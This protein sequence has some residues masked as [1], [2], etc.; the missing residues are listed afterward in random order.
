[1]TN[2]ELYK[3]FGL[4]TE[5]AL[6]EQLK[7]ALELRRDQ[8]QAAVLRKQAVEKISA[9][10]EMELP[11]K[12]TAMQAERDLQR[13]RTELQSS[14]KLSLD[15]V[16]AEVAK[17][18]SGSTEQSKER[19]KNFF[20][21]SKLA[22]HF[23]VTVGEHEV[24]ARIAEI[25]M[26]NGMRPEEMRSRLA[27]QGQLPQIQMVVKEDKAADQLVAAC[28]VKE[29]SLEE[30][31]A[32]QGIESAPATKKTKKKSSKKTASKKK[33]KKKTTKKTKKSSEKS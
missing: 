31:Q 4:E 32:S 13:M 9:L 29:I 23:H 6:K 5:D 27:E 11:E 18:R 1:M 8:D 30:W 33:T 21:L 16:E 2:E 20:I 25:A 26:Q 3:L 19:L 15:E 28:T 17:A 12:T 10:V 7:L 24:N 14:G 22:E